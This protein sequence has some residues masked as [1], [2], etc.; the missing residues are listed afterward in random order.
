MALLSLVPHT[1]Q[2][3]VTDGGDRAERRNED[4]T[5][6]A[7]VSK[8]LRDSKMLLSEVSFIVLTT[9]ATHPLWLPSRLLSTKNWIPGL[10]MSLFHLCL[11][12][13]CTFLFSCK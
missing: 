7:Q 2:P 8:A 9:T 12:T 4:A 13:I 3:A 5:K 11:P 1:D 6:P 10:L